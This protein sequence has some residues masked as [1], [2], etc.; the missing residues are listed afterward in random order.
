MESSADYRIYHATDLSKGTIL[1]ADDGTTL[2]VMNPVK[3]DCI[4]AIEEGTGYGVLKRI[5]ESSN[6]WKFIPCF[7]NR[8][9][10][11]SYY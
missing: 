5:R 1:T 11:Q 8:M 2:L 9:P 4:Q 10:M 3:E 7:S 6:D